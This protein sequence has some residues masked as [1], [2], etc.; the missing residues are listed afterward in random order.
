MAPS[1]A[2][3]FDWPVMIA[4]EEPAL[5]ALRVLRGMMPAGLHLRLM[6]GITRNHACVEIV[7]AHPD[8]SLPTLRRRRILPP[9]GVGV[10]LSASTFS[11]AC[12]VVG[13]VTALPIAADTSAVLTSRIAWAS[14]RINARVQSPVVS[15]TVSSICN[16]TGRRHHREGRRIEQTALLAGSS[17]TRESTSRSA[18][19]Q[20]R[21][22]IGGGT[23]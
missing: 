7:A 3:A 21:A 5:I 20:I 8:P 22:C 16:A 19:E 9:Q 2:N 13:E 10:E 18:A 6:A 17:L 1:S 14:L 4:H 11:L 23:G 15:S 12:S